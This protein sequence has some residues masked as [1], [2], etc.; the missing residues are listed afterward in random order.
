VMHSLPLCHERTAEKQLSKRC[1]RRVA[2]RT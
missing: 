1:N 2:Y